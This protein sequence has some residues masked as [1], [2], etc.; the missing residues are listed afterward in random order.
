M[1]SPSMTTGSAGNALASAPLAASGTTNF[2]V[3]FSAVFEG[4]IQVGATFGTIAATAGLRIDVY[5]RIGTTP[6]N[7]TVAMLSITLA[8]VSGAK[9]LD[10]ALATGKYN[11]VLT[12]LDAT[13][14][15]TA[16]YATDDTIPAVS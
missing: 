14:G 9:S 1:A 10:L 5:R 8:A 12:N 4:Q 16:V 15:L 7:S 11:V 13:N 3:D 6:V 2:N